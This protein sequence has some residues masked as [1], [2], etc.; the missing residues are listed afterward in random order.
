MLDIYKSHTRL[1]A[2][3]MAENTTKYSLYSVYI[4]MAL[5]TYTLI[6]ILKLGSTFYIIKL[7]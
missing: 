2:L 6:I 7:Y 3:C 4:H 1:S 5:M